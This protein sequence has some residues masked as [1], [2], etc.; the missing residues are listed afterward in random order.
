MTVLAPARGQS[1][2]DA[3]AGYGG[4]AAAVLERLDNDSRVILVDRDAHATA[5]LAQRFGDRVEIIRA[6]FLEAAERLVADGT[7]VDMILLDLGVSSPQIDNAERGFSFRRPAALDMRMDQSQRFTAAD[8]VNGYP[9]RELERI[10][11]L[12]GEEPRARAVARA[13]VAARPLADTGQLARVIRRVAA[14]T[15]EID[16]ATRTFQAIRIEV[17]GE[18]TQ[19]EKALPFMV[20]L[21]HPE[22]RLAVISFHSLEDRIVKQF[23]DQES[24]DCICPPKQPI[25]TCG[26]IASLQKL[27]KTPLVA[28]STEIAI[29][30]RARSAKLRAAEKI[31]KNQ[32]RD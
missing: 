25:C 22:G 3:T 21:L 19:L 7:L 12:Y 28:D 2:L 32:R 31:N 30:P 16:A 24:R 8:V 10:I 11:R 6:D 29:N 18:L 14:A 13:I 4:H 26:H 1:Y 27:T 20:R 17:N 5:A 9:E 15:T 23:F